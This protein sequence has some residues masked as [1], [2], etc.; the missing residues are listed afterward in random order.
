MNYPTHSQILSFDI[1]GALQCLVETLQASNTIYA[2]VDGALD[3]SGEI[4]RLLYNGMPKQY[5]YEGTELQTNAALGPILITLPE[6]ARFLYS[7]LPKMAETMPCLLFA[8]P[9]TA[10]DIGLFFRHRIEVKLENN[11]IFLFRFYD[12]NLMKPFIKS[13]SA[14]R[15][16]MFFGPV[17]RIIW[18]VL[19]IRRNR[20][21]HCYALPPQSDDV[22]RLS[23]QILSEQAHPCWEAM[24]TEWRAFQVLFVEDVSLTDLCRYLLDNE[25]QLLQGLSD[26]QVLKKVDA[27]VALA[28][29]YNLSTQYDIYTFCKLELDF[30]PGIH[31]HPKVDALLKCPAKM[32][33][34]KMLDL[35]S[36]DMWTWSELKQLAE[37]YVEDLVI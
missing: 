34:Y 32:P 9:R 18:P 27:T 31:L 15:A 25:A 7:F 30:F 19:D 17:E 35:A 10:R 21:W 13:L 11:N 14:Q 3:E 23:L 12:A 29:T 28:K 33:P 8:S 36:L 5:L 37:E 6:E 1:S 22:F 4:M 20:Q 24:D 2:L 26:E 16:A